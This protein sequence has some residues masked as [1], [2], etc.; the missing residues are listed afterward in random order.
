MSG[1]GSSPGLSLAEWLELAAVAARAK[2]LARL[3]LRQSD[4]AHLNVAARPLQLVVVDSGLDVRDEVA[5]L[6]G[7]LSKV[8]ER[9]SG[10]AGLGVHYAV[11]TGDVVAA[12]RLR[13]L[14]ATDGSDAEIGRA[15]GYPEC[16]VAAYGSIT[17]SGDWLRSLLDGTP[18]GVKAFAA[19]NRM[20]RFLGNWAVL[21]DYFP[22][23]LRCEASRQLARQLDSIG[24]RAGLHAELDR[25]WHELCR[26][27]R[28]AHGE[29]LQ[30]AAP[31]R[32]VSLDGPAIVPRVLTWEL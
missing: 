17:A 5:I 29:I 22:C 28:V 31:P 21:P 1:Q 14:E 16:C 10:A 3:V 20:G 9:G 11:R 2:P 27:I 6:G 4:V 25:A 19:C 23:S 15:L 7:S 32:V 12:D 18:P 26:P 8:G 13:Q 24:R 30:C